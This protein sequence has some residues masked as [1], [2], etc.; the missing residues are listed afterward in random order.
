ML[1]KYQT[2]EVVFECFSLKAVIFYI[3]WV[4]GM[5]WIEKS[6]QSFEMPV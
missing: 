5:N 3:N 6:G 1:L 2:G 4:I